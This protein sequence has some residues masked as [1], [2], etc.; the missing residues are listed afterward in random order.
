ML[1]DAAVGMICSI[2]ASRVQQADSQSKKRLPV[3]KEASLDVFTFIH[4]D[5]FLLFIVRILFSILLAKEIT[6]FMT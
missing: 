6:L 1:L 4:E 5:L 3:I 2:S